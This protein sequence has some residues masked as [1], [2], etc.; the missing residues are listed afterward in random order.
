MENK[1][2][3]KS[4]VLILTISLVLL[5][6]FFS[7][8]IVQTNIFSTNLNKLKYLHLQAN[9]HLKNLE[10]YVKTY[11]DEK[12]KTVVLDDERFDMNIVSKNENNS[13]VYYISISTK[14]DTPIRVLT[15][16]TK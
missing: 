2:M 1:D 5:F 14:D 13:T 4:F 15:T 11:D 12:I 8:N 9:I 3:K 10:E 7:L 16:I 6:S